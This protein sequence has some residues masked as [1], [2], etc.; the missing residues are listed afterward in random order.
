MYIKNL[1]TKVPT[2]KLPTHKKTCENNLLYK[3][4]CCSVSA[5]QRKLKAKS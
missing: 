5:V 2:N 3:P 4:Y 1:A